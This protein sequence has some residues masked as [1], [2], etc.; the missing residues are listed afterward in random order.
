MAKKVTYQLVDDMDNTPIPEGEG[1]TIQFSL[2]GHA[3]E[4]DLGD[5]HAKVLRTMLEKYIKVA[6]KPEKSTGSRGKAS[7]RPSNTAVKRD[8][9]NEVRAWANRNGY[10][11]SDRGRVPL[12]VLEA[13]DAAH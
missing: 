4:I 1:E 11:V 8:D 2:D 13:Y 10:T 9:L 6:R 5:G 12:K 7:S 3:Y